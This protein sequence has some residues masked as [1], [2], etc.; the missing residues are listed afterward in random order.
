[1]VHLCSGGVRLLLPLP[2]ATAQLVEFVHHPD[3]RPDV[4]LLGTRGIGSL[5]TTVMARDSRR[6]KAAPVAAAATTARR[7]RPA[8][9]HPPQGSFSEY[10]VSHSEVPVVVVRGTSFAEQKAGGGSPQ[11][12]G[13]RKV[14]PQASCHHRY[15]GW[16]F[17][18]PPLLLINPLNRRPHPP[19]RRAFADRFCSGRVV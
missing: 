4:L 18:S 7:P 13:G 6:L 9:A 3:L 2:V 11:R 15:T 17:L 14:L 10:V 12:V 19:P 5:R 1:M 16:T 8:A